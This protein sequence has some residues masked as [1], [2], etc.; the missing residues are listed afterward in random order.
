[1]AQLWGGRFTGKTD[2][3]MEVFNSS[4]KF[5]RRMWKADILGSQAYAKALAKSGII[6]N[7]ERDSLIAGLD[8]VAK[9]WES[10]TFEVRSS[11][12]DIH[13]ANERRLG[14][15][16]GSV[17]GKLHTGRSRNDQ[18]ATDMRLW[19]KDESLKLEGFLK[20]LVSVA[21]ARAESEIDV[22]MPGYTHLQVG[23]RRAQPIRWSHWILSYA[24][25]FQSDADRLIQIRQRVSQ[26]PLGSGALAGNPFNVDR[27]F[28]A[29]ELG[30]EGVIPNS[31]VGVGDRDFIVEFLF[32]SSLTSIH[33]SRFAEDLINYSTAEFGFVSLADA[34]S[35]GSSL[36]PQ[37]KNADSL[38][39][40]R[41]K[42][43]RVFGDMAGFMMTLKGLPSTYNKDLQ[44]D[45]EPLFDA[46]DTM[47]AL[48][49]I[50]T[51]VLSTLKIN[52]AKMKAALSIDMLATDLAEYLVRK[53]VRVP[54][55]ET[56]HIAGH[57][58]RI[59]EER[60]FGMDSL[61][62]SDLQQLHSAFT[63][64]V[65]EVWN[66]ET[67]VNRRNAIGGTAKETVLGQIELLKMATHENEVQVDSKASDFN[68][69][70]HPAILAFLKILNSDNAT[71]TLDVSSEPDNL[72]PD[73]QSVFLIRGLLSSRSCVVTLAAKALN[74]P[75]INGESLVILGPLNDETNLDLT[76]TSETERSSL[77][78]QWDSLYDP[79]EQDFPKISI[80]GEDKLK[81]PSTGVDPHSQEDVDVIV[82]NRSI[83]LD[84]IELGAALSGI[85]GQISQMSIASA[86]SLDSINIPVPPKIPARTTSAA[87]PDS[88]LNLFALPFSTVPVMFSKL[89]LIKLPEI[90]AIAED[91]AV[92]VFM[93]ALRDPR[94]NHLVSEIQRFA[95]ETAAASRAFPVAM[96]ASP[97]P[98]K[99]G[100]S[101]PVG[102][103]PK[104]AIFQSYDTTKTQLDL[105]AQAIESFSSKL[106]SALSLLAKSK[107]CEIGF[108]L[109]MEQYNDLLLH[110]KLSLLALSGFGASQ[111]GLRNPEMDAAVTDDALSE[112]TRL[113]GYEFL[114]FDISPTPKS[115]LEK[116]VNIHRIIADHMPKN[117]VGS[118]TSS[119]DFLLP[120]LIY[121]IIRSNPPRL[122]S[123]IRHIQRFRS[124]SK[125][126]GYSAYCLTNISAAVT[127]LETVELSGLKVPT[128]IFKFAT[129]SMS[130]GL[131]V[132]PTNHHR[133]LTN[134]KPT[135]FGNP[136]TEAIQ[137]LLDGPAK[138]SQQI[139]GLFGQFNLDVP[140]QQIGTRRLS[141]Q[142][143]SPHISRQPSNTGSETHDT[144]F[145][146]GPP[147]PPRKSVDE[148]K[149]LKENALASKW[150]EKS[151]TLGKK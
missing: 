47:F 45:K 91:E 16:I 79:Q 128:D 116:I 132:L 90:S 31:L 3:L 59:A 78:A 6:T 69:N 111:L 73:L 1:M 35:T 124:I 38:E 26:N 86:E 29:K 30:F 57:A 81:L 33:L 95:S 5:D 2:P 39:L 92:Q 141:G 103:I 88:P 46:Y 85:G 52:P 139:A 76:K 63:E 151:K 66:F 143:A 99:A 44:E 127:Y 17:A 56:H 32:W 129:N 65:S 9:E 137:Q 107:G 147:L 20:Q 118:N 97:T 11:D 89:D 113:V 125:M 51:G 115:K 4:L 126:E 102:Q 58:V 22:L 40:L 27:V 106:H 43:G 110:R 105:Q 28:L 119:A 50:A 138:I 131:L 149:S 146:R 42:S 145:P 23:N 70:N 93:E 54:F 68:S 25:Y 134:E 55:R 48:L 19:L 148:L 101:T 109:N 87:E 77:W 36:M 135:D 114:R 49:Q 21:V 133:T 24:F 8:L 112:L 34:Y 13:T 120:A 61:K 96:Q 53:G 82:I 104:P 123:N 37:K 121:T 41:G 140:T 75:M 18:V 80:I 130:N 60:G 94:A 108:T 144:I 122:F 100:E 14:E 64:D 62:L 7:D 71:P 67:S 72:S 142:S 136:I 117:I 12:E 83:T 15:H 98:S 74:S 84:D 10:D 150:S